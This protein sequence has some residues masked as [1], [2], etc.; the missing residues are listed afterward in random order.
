MA[1]GK[2]SWSKGPGL[3]QRQWDTWTS[4][5]Q[6]RCQRGT[7]SHNDSGSPG[8]ADSDRYNTDVVLKS[9]VL[10]NRSP[11]FSCLDLGVS[12]F[13]RCFVVIH[14]G[15][16]DANSGL[17]KRQATGVELDPGAIL[18]AA[19]NADRNGLRMDT[20]HPCEV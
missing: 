19:G 3:R 14:N 20:Y 15:N 8:G 11:M 16:L 1:G 2:R 7:A 17:I 18:S 5:A 12:M 10:V 6:I 4:S 13:R 9:R